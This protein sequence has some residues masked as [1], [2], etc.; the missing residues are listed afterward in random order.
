MKIIF[1]RKT[2]SGILLLVVVG[3]GSTDD[4]IK[5]DGSNSS[6]DASITENSVVLNVEQILG[7]WL[8]ESLHLFSG[9]GGV[10]HSADSVSLYLT[11]KP[12]GTF[13][14]TH[15]YPIGFI[16]DRELLAEKGL[17]HVKEVIVTI[18]GDYKIA[19]NQLTI[20]VLSS[21]V[22]P[23][24]AAELDSDFENPG[25]LWVEEV[26]N[27]GKAEV[28]LGENDDILVFRVK[29]GEITA[30]I[31]YYR[32]LTEPNLDSNPPSQEKLIGT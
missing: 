29:D 7:T 13:Q 23:T 1:S 11:F 28:F 21:D 2:I 6:P 19:A 16:A 18:L 4:L 31:I 17:Q 10:W 30:E 9:H 12:D 8:L 3:C 15:K 25:F 27:T 26:G 22:N 24:Q 5:E 32:L 14:A 20:H